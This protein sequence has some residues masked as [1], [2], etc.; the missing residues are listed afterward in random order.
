M[1]MM[2]FC[3]L[4]ENFLHEDEQKLQAKADRILLSENI[5]AVAVIS[6]LLR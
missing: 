1:G 6:Y 2:R 4:Y 5:L 3:G